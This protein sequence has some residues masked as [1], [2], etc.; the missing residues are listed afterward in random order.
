MVPCS[1]TTDGESSRPVCVI[2]EFE[3]GV[4][5]V[6]QLV[7]AWLFRCTDKDDL[8][9]SLAGLVVLNTV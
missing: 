5:A 2:S 7:R 4:A 6:A 3:G 9:L 1:V 8:S